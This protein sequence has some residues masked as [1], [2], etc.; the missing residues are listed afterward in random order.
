MSRLFSEEEESFFEKLYRIEK[1]AF[2][3]GFAVGLLI[4]TAITILI[5]LIR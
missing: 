3:R 4:P 1:K 2:W 5:A